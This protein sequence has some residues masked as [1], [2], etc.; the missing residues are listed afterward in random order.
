MLIEGV[1]GQHGDGHSPRAGFCFPGANPPGRLQPVHFRHL[2][3]HQN[4]LE[5][6]GRGF[7][8]GFL[9][10]DC[11][12]Y[13]QRTVLKKL[14]DDLAVGGAVLDQQNAGGRQRQPGPQ[15]GRFQRGIRRDQRAGGA[16]ESNREE[17]F[18]APLQLAVQSDLPSHQLHQPLANRQS[19]TRSAILAGDGGVRLEKAFKHRRV[20]RRGNANARIADA[21]PQSFT[22]LRLLDARHINHHRA[23]RRELDRITHQI[24]QNL[25]QPGRI[26][27]AMWVHPRRCPA[28]QIQPFFL[29]MRRHDPRDV[30][31]QFHQIKGCG[32]QLDLTGLDFGKIKNVIDDGQQQFPGTL[33]R[34]DVIPLVVI[35]GRFSQQLAHTEN[36]VHRRADFMA[37][38][39]QKFALGPTG[40]LG[41]LLGD[42]QGS[43]QSLALQDFRIQA[44][45]AVLQFGGALP[46]LGL[47]VAVIPTQAFDHRVE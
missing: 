31:D 15:R 29:G 40:D 3:I 45:V 41:L 27:D 35:E 22:R 43:F 16:R 28:G 23:P 33:Q 18:T 36:G 4:Q 21:E 38:P 17:K 25:P 1:G 9:A 7:V 10:V 42:A 8:H 19:Q 47:Q 34:M 26:A 37:H 32:L 24:E 5:R 14:A 11:F 44:R 2:H 6:L 12:D 46:N 13:R 20:L 30:L 39:R